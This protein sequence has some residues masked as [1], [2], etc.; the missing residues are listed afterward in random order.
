MAK[1]LFYGRTLVAR[2]PHPRLPALE[3]MS[4]CRVLHDTQGTPT[5]VILE[6]ETGAGTQ[7]MSM[8]WPAA[9]TLLGFLKAAQLDTGTPF[10]DDPRAPASSR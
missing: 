10:P 5:E 9:M 4:A 1:T 6:Y 7:E 3:T 8:P 2:K